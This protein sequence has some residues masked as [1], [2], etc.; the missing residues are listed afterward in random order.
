MAQK[1]RRVNRAKLVFSTPCGISPVNVQSSQRELVQRQVRVRRRSCRQVRRSITSWLRE[2]FYYDGRPRYFTDEGI[3]AAAKMILRLLSLEPAER[4]EVKDV[5]E[6]EWLGKEQWVADETLGGVSRDVDTKEGI[7]G[8]GG[9]G[10]AAGT[11][12]NAWGP[13]RPGKQSTSGMKG[14][15]DV[16]TE[17]T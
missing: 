15:K 2:V 6:D 1:V 8:G 13:K 10:M 11:G 3:E 4:E 9:K 12:E 5:L 17:K 16:V 14:E 7:H